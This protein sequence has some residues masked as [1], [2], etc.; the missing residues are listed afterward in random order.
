MTEMQTVTIARARGRTLLMP[1]YTVPPAR[2]CVGSV[3]L[4]TLLLFTGVT[5]AASG[6]GNEDRELGRIQAGPSNAELAALVRQSTNGQAEVAKQS[7][8]VSFA[9][10]FD[11]DGNR[12]VAVVVQL[13]G[14]DVPRKLASTMTVLNPWLVSTEPRARNPYETASDKALILFHGT[15]KEW[16]GDKPKRVFMLL[17]AV[18]SDMKVIDR[19][20][21]DNVIKLPKAARGDCLL[22]GTEEAK[23]ITYWNGKTYLWQQYGD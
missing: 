11:G 19:R 22:T 4:C 1:L 16:S 21:K 9:G 2:T 10:D 15:Q 8:P 17:D 14:K 13:K 3:A 7:S 18:Y 12:D 23:G 5:S 6:D 20:A